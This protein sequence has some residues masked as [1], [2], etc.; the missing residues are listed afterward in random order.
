MGGPVALTRAGSD[1]AGWTCCLGPHS[2]AFLT[3]SQAGVCFLSDFYLCLLL[4][5][6][7]VVP[8][9]EGNILSTKLHSL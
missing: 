9:A 5:V 2:P 7:I 4:F 1:S 8:K 3:A 6:L